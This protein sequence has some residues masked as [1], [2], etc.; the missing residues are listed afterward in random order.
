MA[1]WWLADDPAPQLPAVRLDEV[2]VEIVG[3]GIT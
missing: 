3:G 1:S 2:D